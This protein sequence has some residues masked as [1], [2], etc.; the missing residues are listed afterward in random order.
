MRATGARVAL[1]RWSC[2]CRW[3]RTWAG[4]GQ[5]GLVMGVKPGCAGFFAHAPSG[6]ELLNR[7]R[8]RFEAVAGGDAFG[9]GVC[10]SEFK[11]WAGVV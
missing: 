11:V 8:Q 6:E 1:R 10:V 9:H 2:L 7:V 4:G 3:R 5:F